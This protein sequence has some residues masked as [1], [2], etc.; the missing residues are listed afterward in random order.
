M[1]RFGAAAIELKIA[2]ERAKS[3]L[4]ERIQFV[5]Y[6]RANSWTRT[7]LAPHHCHQLPFAHSHLDASYQNAPTANVGPCL[8]RHDK[9]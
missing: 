9:T 6:E 2:L 7:R 3:D 4:R 1:N 8:E 5:A